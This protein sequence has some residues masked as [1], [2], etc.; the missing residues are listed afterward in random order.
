MSQILGLS[1][2]QIID[3]PGL[4]ALVHQCVDEV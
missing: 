2:A 4:V 3:N 1:R